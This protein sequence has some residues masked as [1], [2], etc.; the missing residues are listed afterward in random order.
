MLTTLTLT[1]AIR[2]KW[3]IP[4]PL[5]GCT[6]GNSQPTVEMFGV[7]KVVLKVIAYTMSVVIFKLSSKSL[8]HISCCVSCLNNV[9]DQASESNVRPKMDYQFG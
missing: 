7:H 1:P 8:G 5:I 2:S 3:F 4:E 6:S 9:A